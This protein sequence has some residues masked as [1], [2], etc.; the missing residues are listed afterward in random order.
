[1][2]LYRV[3]KVEAELTVRLIKEELGRK[4]GGLRIIVVVLLILG[5]VLDKFPY[6]IPQLLDQGRPIPFRP[7]FPN[8]IETRSPELF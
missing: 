4:V 2:K 8:V 5:N 3:S 6:N 1:M 7:V